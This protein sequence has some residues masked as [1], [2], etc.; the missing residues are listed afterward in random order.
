MKLSF[1]LATVV[2]VLANKCRV[3]EQEKPVCKEVKRVVIEEFPIKNIKKECHPIK[4]PVKQTIT[5][6]VSSDSCESSI[7]KVERKKPVVTNNKVCDYKDSKISDYDPKG[8]YGKKGPKCRIEKKTTYITSY[9]EV[10]KWRCNEHKDVKYVPV[11]Y[12]E[13]KEICRDVIHKDVKRVKLEVTEKKCH[14]EKF[15]REICDPVKDYGKD[16]YDSYDSTGKDSY[17]SVGDG[18]SAEV[19]YDSNYDIKDGYGQTGGY[20]SYGKDDSY[21]THVKKD[22]YDSYGQDNSYGKDDG[23]GKDE[24]YGKDE[25]YGK[26]DSLTR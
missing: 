24:I 23:Y 21:N 2:C 14:V 15:T 26:K 20:D 11:T 6:H 8:D 7:D 1:V 13:K 18:Y 22:S 10:T 19:T 25:S 16:T 17:D 12:H 9:D 4:E 3:V 5:L